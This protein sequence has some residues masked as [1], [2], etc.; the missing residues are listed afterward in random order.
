MYANISASQTVHAINR[1]ATKIISANVWAVHRI[2]IVHLQGRAIFRNCRSGC[3]FSVASKMCFNNALSFVAY[4][5]TIRHNAW[6]SF[7]IK[8]HVYMLI[9]AVDPYQRITNRYK[10]WVL[11]RMINVSQNG[12]N[13]WKPILNN[14]YTGLVSTFDGVSHWTIRNRYV[15]TAVWKPI[16]T[17]LIEASLHSKPSYFGN[18]SRIDLRAMILR[19]TLTTTLT[20]GTET[21]CTRGTDV[22][23]STRRLVEVLIE[24]L[25]GLVDVDQMPLVQCGHSDRYVLIQFG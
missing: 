19:S 24:N 5:S 10:R 25:A 1:P 16:S 14:E 13:W 15:E 11:I 18:T 2:A 7:M 21:R 22:A 6:L 23:N 12:W 9:Y 4:C 17:E 20:T 8:I 3:T